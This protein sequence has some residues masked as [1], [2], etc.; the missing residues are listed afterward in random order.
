[1][2]DVL[3]FWK[4]LWVDNKFHLY[5]QNLQPI[6]N[7]QAL[8]IQMIAEFIENLQIPKKIDTSKN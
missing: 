7:L 2:F 1:M 6:C 8:G 5:K 4:T 3:A